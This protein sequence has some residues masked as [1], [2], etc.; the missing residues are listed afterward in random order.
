M[1]Q[2]TLRVMPGFFL[3]LAFS[4][5]LIPI[6]WLL[7]W[8]IAAAFHELFHILALR[9]C[10]YEI[11]SVQI[12]GMGAKIETNGE[13]GIKMMLSALAGPLAG[14]VLMLFVRVM[15]RIAL[16]ALF[17]SAANLLPVFPL[18]GGRA[19]RCFLSM[20]FSQEGVDKI[21]APIETVVLLGLFAVSLYAMIKLHL[22]IAPLLAVCMLLNR[23]KYLAI[24]SACEYNIG[25]RY[26][27]G[28]HYDRFTQSDSA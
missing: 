2:G 19:V 25:N 9:L 12:N 10:G 26:K 21:V 4:L 5:L 13:P 20:F 3:S 11:L 15:P 22:G 7:S 1:R 27:R 8:L 17:Q 24:K 28:K 16:C 6:P 23:K 14:L 18:D